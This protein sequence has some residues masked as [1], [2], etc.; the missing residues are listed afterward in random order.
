MLEAHWL[1]HPE[2][3]GVSKSVEVQ[4]G[5]EQRPISQAVKDRFAIKVS[6]RLIV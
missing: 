6:N 3:N 5:R 1:N 2:D 4:G